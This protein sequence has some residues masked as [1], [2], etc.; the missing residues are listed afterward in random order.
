MDQQQ[1]PFVQAIIDFEVATDIY[2]ADQF[3]QTRMRP[4]SR[5]SAWGP[6]I[7]LALLAD[8]ETAGKVA[9]DAAMDVWNVPE[10]ATCESGWTGDRCTFPLFHD[11]PHSNP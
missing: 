8:V 9:A 2:N 5:P 11:G 6:T 10:T 3:R 7:A 4:G 1:D